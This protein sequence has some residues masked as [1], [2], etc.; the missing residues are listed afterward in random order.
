MDEQLDG[1]SVSPQA[2]PIRIGISSCL[3]GEAVR[4]DGGHKHDGYITETLGRYITWV[5]VC[6]E[7]EVGMGT[8]RESVRLVGSRQ[9]PQMVGNQTRRDWTAAMQSYAERRVRELE[10]MRLHGYLLKKGSPSCGMERVKIY[11]EQ[12]MPI[13][14]GPGLFARELMN[15]MS[16][17]PI[18]EE[19]RLNDP[20]LRENFIERVF[21]YY[22]WHRLTASDPTPNDLVRF[23]TQHKLTL[24]AHDPRGYR[25]LGR[26]VAAA[27]KTDFRE[28]LAQYGRQFMEVLKIKATPQKHANVL[29][30]LKG[31][32][33]R[34]IDHPDKEE[35]TEV[36]ESYRQGYVPLIVPI[37]LLKHHFRRHTIEWIEEQTYMAPYP[38]ELMLRN[39][40]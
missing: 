12:G 7:V 9:S 36:I 19:G 30:H 33:K 21:A 35:L 20:V 25:E 17:L 3:L 13:G 26:R 38:A 22:R 24:F 34:S 15:R 1:G 40:V 16:S 14:T 31:F 10:S 27:G 5:P 18:E 28:S 6:P 4:W 37:T 23:H 2:D 39:H 8:P 32:L 11:S 29:Y